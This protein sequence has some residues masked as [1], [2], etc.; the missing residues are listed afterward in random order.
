MHRSKMAAKGQRLIVFGVEGLRRALHIVSNCG[1]RA[2]RSHARFQFD[3]VKKLLANQRAVVA[4][5]RPEFPKPV[6]RSPFVILN[7]RGLALF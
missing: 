3:R 2:K 5:L 7:P 1:I 4:E 6:V